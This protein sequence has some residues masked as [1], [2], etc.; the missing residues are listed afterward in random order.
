MEAITGLVISVNALNGGLSY[1]RAGMGII[2]AFRNWC[3]DD[4]RTGTLV[5]ILENWWAK[6]EGPRLY[7]P[8][9]FAGPP[10]RAFIEC[11]SQ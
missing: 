9:R 5:P 3:E 1:A 11:V 7:Y 10:L 6:L 2:G 8:S 4:F